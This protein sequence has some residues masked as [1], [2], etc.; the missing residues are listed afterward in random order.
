[1]RYRFICAPVSGNGGT[2]TVVVAVVNH[3]AELN[4]NVDLFLTLE[5]ENRSWLTKINSNVN[6]VHFTAHTKIEK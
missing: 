2:E 3:L 6:I 1:M 4:K 5:P